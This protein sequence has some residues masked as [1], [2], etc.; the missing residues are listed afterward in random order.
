MSHIMSIGN[1][2]DAI[3]TTPLNITGNETVGALDLK[4]ALEHSELE[5]GLAERISGI[6]SPLALGVGREVERYRRANLMLHR[7]DWSNRQKWNGLMGL[8]AEI[9]QEHLAGIGFLKKL[10]KKVGRAVKSAG[11]SVARTVR[12]VRQSNL[13]KKVAEP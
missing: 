5:H 11:K 6:G 1:P 8:A 9:D 10:R 12:A 4:L 13:I 2:F 3:R 7:P